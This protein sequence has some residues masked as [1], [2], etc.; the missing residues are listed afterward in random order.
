MKQIL[1]IQIEPSFAAIEEL[2]LKTEESFIKNNIDSLTYFPIIHFIDE[3]LS[4]TV[5]FNK[6]LNKKHK[7]ELR[8]YLNSVVTCILEAH[9]FHIESPYFDLKKGIINSSILANKIEKLE[10]KHKNNKSI[11]LLQSKV[12]EDFYFFKS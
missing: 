6:N 10:F 12:I 5:L 2:S 11:V 8:I 7:I 1:N 4:N 9:S 3:L